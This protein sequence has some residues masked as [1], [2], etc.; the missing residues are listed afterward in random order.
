[1]HGVHAYC[2]FPVSRY[3]SILPHPV[4]RGYSTDAMAKCL[5]YYIYIYIY[6]DTHYSLYE[7]SSPNINEAINIPN[8][9][10]ISDKHIIPALILQWC[11]DLK[12]Y[13]RFCMIRSY[14]QRYA[15]KITICVARKGER[16]LRAH[17]SN[18]MLTQQQP[19]IP[20]TKAEGN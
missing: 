8:N 5:I 3:W 19:K 1:M 18:A 7:T 15:I 9:D 11:S 16:C 12:P 2:D 20:T 4:P 17:L 14:W 6:V 10:I 13:C